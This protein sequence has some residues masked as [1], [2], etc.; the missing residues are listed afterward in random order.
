[1]TMCYYA[2]LQMT[3]EPEACI[4]MKTNTSTNLTSSCYVK[5]G[6][7][8]CLKKQVLHLCVTQTNRLPYLDPG[9]RGPVLDLTSQPLQRLG[10]PAGSFLHLLHF[11]VSKLA[12]LPLCV[13]LLPLVH[14]APQLL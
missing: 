9:P 8:A 12:V 11:E 14:S 4:Y 5:S 1:M 7:T 13:K 2:S 10:D 6:T 3:V